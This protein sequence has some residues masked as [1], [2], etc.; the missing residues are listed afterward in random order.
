MS[1]S[2][3]TSTS[4]TA[5][6]SGMLLASADPDRL[7]DWYVAVLDP[8]VS[9]T[10]GEPSYDVLDFGGFYVML[11]RRDDIQERNPD[12]ARVILN[13]HVDDARATAERIER[14]GSRWV[15]PLED[16]DGSFFATAADPDGNFV[17]IIT[18]SDE[19]MAAMG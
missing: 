10:P 13:F 17:Q 8:S 4:R 1:T 14:L 16:R 6:L 7:R 9:S 11:D 18:L 5:T 15:S 12:P 19:A 2:D 3:S